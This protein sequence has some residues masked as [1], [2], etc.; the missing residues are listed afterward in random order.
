MEGIM[1]SAQIRFSNFQKLFNDFVDQH[2]HL[3]QRGMLK[4]FAQRL[5]FSD[6][7]L[8]HIKCNRKNIGHNVARAIEERLKLPHGWMDREHHALTLPPAHPSAAA[9]S[10]TPLDEK[11][12]LFID[13]ALMLF[14]SQPAEARE[15]MIELLR[16][17][18]DAQA[19]T[20]TTR[21]KNASPKSRV[22]PA[23]P[24]KR[25]AVA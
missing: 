19:E 8:S 24:R 13:T 16:E 3:P 4:L 12:Q 10:A 2:A 1:D 15:L 20:T 17:R 18:L 7:Y 11:E 21:T 23:T 9:S 25:A 5:G 14:R 6:R 22:S